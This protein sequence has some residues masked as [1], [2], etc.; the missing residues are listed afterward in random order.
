MSKTIETKKNS[1]SFIVYDGSR[2]PRYYQISRQLFRTLFWGLPSF[3][4]IGLLIA[5]LATTAY[6]QLRKNIESVDPQIVVEL[7]EKSAN[8]EEEKIAADKLVQDL[9]KKLADTANL[10]NDEKINPLSILNLYQSVPGAQDLSQTPTLSMDDFQVTNTG[11]NT[12]VK[13][14]LVN[15]TKDS[16]R[17]SGFIFVVLRMDQSMYFY[18]DS[19][20]SEGDMQIPF[21][22][23]EIFATSRFRPVEARFPAPT[24]ATTALVKILIF[25]RT[26]DLM[27]KRIQTSEIKP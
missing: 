5:L 25:S 22:N 8:L 4:I 7:K 23:G 9:Q 21:S 17:V 24:K 6:Q 3:G 1:L 14:N 10:S 13:F 15:V 19:S 2:G 11:G 12:V 20:F 27:F 16:E 26:G 18:P